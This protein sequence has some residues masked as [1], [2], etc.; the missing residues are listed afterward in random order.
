MRIVTTCSRKGLETYGHRWLDGMH[1]WPDAEFKFY[2]EG[3]TQPDGTTGKDMDELAE[4]SAWKWEHVGYIPPD[5]RFDV[6]KF[7]NK[8]FAAYDALYDYD[9]I[10]V[11]LDADVTTYR[12]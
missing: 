4:F 9:G 11:W 12:K 10:G 6:V 1:N 3:F 8:V 2:T 7:A 5:W